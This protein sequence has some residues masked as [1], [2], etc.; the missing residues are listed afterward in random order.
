M[1]CREKLAKEH[2]ECI[3]EICGGGC[4]GCP[5]DYGYLDR[6]LYCESNGPN[7][8]TECWDR[9]IPEETV[10][11]D[12]ICWDKILTFVDDTM[13]K[14]DRSVMIS[15]NPEAGLTLYISPYSKE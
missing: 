3:D 11:T 9:E 6:P 13:D 10:K 15:V 4:Q 14:K 1:T 7:K 12:V 8:C 5:H 2:P